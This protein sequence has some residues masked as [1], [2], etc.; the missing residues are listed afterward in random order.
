MITIHIVSSGKG[1]SGKSTFSTVLNALLRDYGHN[2]RLIDADPQKK[3][4]IRMYGLSD[5]QTILGAVPIALGS[6]IDLE[7]QPMEILAS[8]E[9]L[10]G[11]PIGQP[12]KNQDNGHVI[13]DLAAETDT[14]LN[15]WISVVNLTAIAK[16]SDIE[17]IKWWV[18]DTDA[19]SLQE[20]LSSAL[21][22]AGIKHILVKNMTKAR[23]EDKWA[24][25]IASC[26]G[27]QDILEKDN[28]HVTTFPK[29]YG[30]LVDDFRQHHITWETCL[31]ASRTK[32]FQQVDMVK[33]GIV[34]TWLRT[35]RENISVVLPIQQKEKKK[36]IAKKAK[37]A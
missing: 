18:A 19:G 30:S 1:S 31:E 33:A 10:R 28:V 17:I 8:A 29:L 35:C 25:A 12:A 5:D 37:A 4:L 32:G 3:V 27:L 13:V 21:G 15:E 22:F 24:R 2:T 16:Q 6:D 9:D 7:D 36:A 11:A 34:D 20:F 14:F 26:P 23:R